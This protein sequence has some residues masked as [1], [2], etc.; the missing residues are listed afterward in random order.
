MQCHAVH[1][2]SAK[3][4]LSIKA[5]EALKASKWIRLLLNLFSTVRRVHII[6]NLSVF[7]VESW[8]DN[9]RTGRKMVGSAYYFGVIKICSLNLY[10]C[11]FSRRK[12]VYYK[13]IPPSS[14]LTDMQ[15]CDLKISCLKI[16]YLFFCLF[17]KAELTQAFCNCIVLVALDRQSVE[18]VQE[19]RELEKLKN[20]WGWATSEGKI[21]TL[22]WRQLSVLLSNMVL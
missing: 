20:F 4:L 17:S 5:T 3:C 16:Y 2:I 15:V 9:F 7:E 8:G 13:C 22:L 10:I 21:K 6:C 14:G 12:G 1:N 18:N 11:Y 19:S